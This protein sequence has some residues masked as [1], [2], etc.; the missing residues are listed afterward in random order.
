MRDYKE[1][2]AL[3]MVTPGVF[4]RLYRQYGNLTRFLPVRRVIFLG[5]K[6]TEALYRKALEEGIF[7]A[8]DLE[9]V[10]FLVED[11]VL[12]FAQ[13]HEKVRREMESILAGR[14]L[15]RGITGWYYQQFLKLEYAKHCENEYYLTWDGD[16][17]PCAEFSM[18]SPGHSPESVPGAPEAPRKPYFDMKQEYRQEYFE[19]MEKL[20]PGMTKVL[21][22][23]F[24]S[25]HMLFH[26]ETVLR[27]T[28]AIEE[29][30]ALAGGTFWERILSTIGGDRMQDAA[31]SEFETYG[32]YVAMTNPSMYRLRE[33]HSFRLGGEFFDP[34]T[35]KESDYQ[36]LGKD[37]TAISF[38][39]DQS[40]REDHR[41][42]FDNP[43]YQ[44][45]L[46]ARQM[47]ELA[48]Q[49]FEEGYKE[50]WKP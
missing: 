10:S 43:E 47:L 11:E 27:L 23:S 28:G 30:P 37:F 14:E 8:E 50:T 7:P 34:A 45:K 5:S 49:E 4:E 33:W 19:T 21:G 12:S 35:I 20:I 26:K 3:V 42:L 25:E 1:Y 40:V 17:I 16:T 2:D 36:W 6:E 32:T 15:P 48:Q 44:K 41:N 24:I 29:N 39:K 18:F 9:R 13:V 31:F 46:S 22:P 38:E